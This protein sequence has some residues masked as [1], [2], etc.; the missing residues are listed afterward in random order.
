MKPY[1]KLAFLYEKDWGKFSL[2]YLDLLNNI[3]KSLNFVPSTILDI[4]CGTGDL[5]LE[6]HKR[7]YKVVGA[8]ISP[9][10]IKISKTKN[11][12]LEFIVSDMSELNLGKTFDLVVCP[13]DSLNYLLSDEK[14][15]ATFSKVYEHLN[16]DGFFV[17]DIN[18]PNLYVKKHHGTIDRDVEGIKFKQILKYDTE[19]KL[20]YTVFEFD[21]AETEEHIQRAHTKDEIIKKLIFHHYN[22]VGAYKNLQL[23]EAGGDSE[24]VYIVARK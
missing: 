10:M 6:L 18:T 24:K 7:G 2:G 8:D 19:K 4:A 15:D 14:I 11:P 16:T 9:E 17:F 21:N 20:A 13:F 5:I 3:F 1:E 23:E 22:I 12:N